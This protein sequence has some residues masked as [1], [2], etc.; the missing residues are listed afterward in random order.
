[1]GLHR[2]SAVRELVAQGEDPLAAMLH[3]LNSDLAAEMLVSL[4][5]AA[6]LRVTHPLRQ[7]PVPQTDSRARPT[8][9]RQVVGTPACPLATPGRHHGR[10]LGERRFFRTQF[11]MKTSERD[12][13]VSRDDVKRRNRSALPVAPTAARGRRWDPSPGV[14]GWVDLRSPRT[15]TLRR[16]EGWLDRRTR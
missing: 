4:T 11:V 7:A 1:M 2:R 10:A 5:R 3:A 9:H 15:Y 8:D 6:L 13:L 12:A 16:T 14:G